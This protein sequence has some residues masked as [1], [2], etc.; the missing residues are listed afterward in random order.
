MPQLGQG[1]RL[2]L[3]DAL[4]GDPE[5]LADLLEGTDPPVVETEPQLHH[6]ALTLG[7]CGERIAYCRMQHRPGRDVVRNLRAAILDQVGQAEVLFVTDWLLE[8]DGVLVDPLDL[9]HPVDRDL[10]RPAISSTVGSRPNS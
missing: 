10:T 2:D 8:R 9:T 6:L 7:K 3:P 5:G 4:T 1:L